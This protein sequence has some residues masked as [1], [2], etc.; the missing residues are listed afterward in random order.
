MQRVKVIVKTNAGKSEVLEYDEEK[1]AYRI[2]V[3]EPPEKGKANLAVVKLMSRHFKKP[4]RIVSGFTS[5]EKLV[6]I[7]E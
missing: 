5:K 4:A 1:Q 6:E 3:K 2:K 7:S